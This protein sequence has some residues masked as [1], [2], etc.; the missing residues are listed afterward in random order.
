V[1]S[2]LAVPNI[3]SRLVAALL[4]PTVAPAVVAFTVMLCIAWFAA[5]QNQAAHEQRSRT[6]VL[7]E[8]SVIRAKLE[9]N[10]SANVQLV[11]GLVA[12]I[13]G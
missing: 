13:A 5:A 8:L 11:R 12:V 2:L 9:G 4:R 3:V 7:K 1:L 6:D 10:I